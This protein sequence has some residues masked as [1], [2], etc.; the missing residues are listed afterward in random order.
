MNTSP[1]AQAP[2]CL[3]MPPRH[4]TSGN[5][6]ARPHHLMSARQLDDFLTARRVDDVSAGVP[7][8]FE[9]GSDGGIAFATGHIRHAGYLDT[10]WFEAPP[11]WNKVDDDALLKALLENGLRCDTTIVLYGRNMLGAARVAHLLLYAGVRDVRLLDGGFDAWRRAG[12]PIAIGSPHRTPAAADFGDVFPAHPEYLIG[13]D[14]AR[15]MLA[16]P[17]AALASIRTWDELTGKTSGYDYIPAR[18]DIPGARWGRAGENGDINSMSAYQHED[19]TMRDP[20]EIE[21]MWRDA[22]I[23]RQ[24]HV[25]FYCGTGW[26]ASMA[27]MYAWLMGW[28]RIAVFDG[29]WFEWSSRIGAG[30]T[31]THASPGSNAGSD[32]IRQPL[33]QMPDR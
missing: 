32:D 3:A 22:G 19:G 29:G 10:T 9:V 24:L 11:F 25:A 7:C 1:I 12:L 18:G 2:E 27:F 13:M 21:A 4:V 16:R 30:S 15:A 31:R 17:D 6:L 20:D 33:C 28:E 14:E 23:D 8:I 26:R 5:R